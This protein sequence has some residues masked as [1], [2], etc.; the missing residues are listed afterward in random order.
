MVRPRN[1]PIYSLQQALE[2]D[3]LVLYY[4]PILNLHTGQICAVEALV[5]WQ[6]PQL[7]YCLLA[8]F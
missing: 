2:K 4:Q 1:K 5:R 8:S 3:E 7:D 6:H